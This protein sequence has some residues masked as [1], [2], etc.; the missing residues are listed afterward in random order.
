[1]MRGAHGVTRTGASS[2]AVTASGSVFSGTGAGQVPNSVKANGRLTVRLK[3]TTREPVSVGIDVLTTRHGAVSSP[4]VRSRKERFSRPP[5]PAVRPVGFVARR[6]GDLDGADRDDLLP[7]VGS[8]GVDRDGLW[9]GKARE[10][11]GPDPGRIDVEG[12][13]AVERG[14]FRRRADP[15]RGWHTARRGARVRQ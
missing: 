1:M 10:P 14:P 13:H 4:L 12:G 11:A 6:E 2:P 5:C 3:S 15:A 7:Q 9:F 8:R